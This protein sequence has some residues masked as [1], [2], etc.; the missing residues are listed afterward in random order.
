MSF[1]NRLVVILGAAGGIGAA[2]SHRLKKDGARLLLAG[3]TNEKGQA[4]AQEL[5]AEWTQ[6]DATQSSQVDAVCAHAGELG[7]FYGVVNCVGSLILKPAHLTTDDEWRASIAANLDTSFF[8]VRQATKMMAKDGGSIVLL[9]TAPARLGMA[10]HEAIAAAKAGV[11]GL[12]LAA[13]ASYAAQQIR[14]NCVAPGLV[15]TPLTSRL[16][17]NDANRKMSE[18]MHPM[19]RL[20]KPEDIASAVAWLLNPEQGWVT[21]QVLGVDGGLGTL[22]PREHR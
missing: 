2:L 3:R 13:A 12:A 9:S 4:L 7:G 18:T 14:V 6:C 22:R 17:S 1:D 11:I 15:E 16:T 21:G 5:G 10:N 8:L 19:G 20:G